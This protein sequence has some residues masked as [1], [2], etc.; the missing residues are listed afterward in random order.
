MYDFYL[1]THVCSTQEDIQKTINSV[2]EGKLSEVREALESQPKLAWIKDKGGR[3]L[4]HIA[5]LTDNAEMVEFLSSKYPRMLRE[6]RDY[7]SIICE[8]RNHFPLDV[9]NQ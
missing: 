6:I 9:Y 5:V 4:L 1:T 8:R 2:K 7:V 3:S